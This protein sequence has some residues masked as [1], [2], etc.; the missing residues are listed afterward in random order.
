[1]PSKRVSKKIYA[2]QQASP[3]TSGEQKEVYC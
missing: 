3:R 2:M 1:M